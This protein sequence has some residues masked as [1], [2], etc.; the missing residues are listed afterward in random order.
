MDHLF[1][2]ERFLLCDTYDTNNVQSPDP[3][4][5]RIGLTRAKVLQAVS[6]FPRE[7]RRRYAALKSNVRTMSSQGQM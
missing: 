1:I 6:R 5:P 2:R 7:T 3:A 4:S